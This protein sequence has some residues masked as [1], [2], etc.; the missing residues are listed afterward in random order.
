MYNPPLHLMTFFYSQLTSL[1]CFNKRVLR[2]KAT[3]FFEYC[4][5]VNIFFYSTTINGSFRCSSFHISC[6]KQ[7]NSRHSI[8]IRRTI[9]GN[10]PHSLRSLST[11]SGCIKMSKVRFFLSSFAQ[12]RKFAAFSAYC[13]SLSSLYWSGCETKCRGSRPLVSLLQD[14]FHFS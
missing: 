7:L 1:Y 6:L 4:G 14:V 11:F 9:C 13:E 10:W 8:Q 2:M 3:A 5:W 12:L